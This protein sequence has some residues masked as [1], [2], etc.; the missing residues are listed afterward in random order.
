MHW[1]YTPYV[2]PLILAAVVSAPLTVY[3]WR[4]RAAPGAAPLALFMLA[5]AVWSLGTALELAG[6]DVATKVFWAEVQYLGVVTVPAAWLAFALQYTDTRDQ[7]GRSYLTRRNLALLAIEPLMTLLLVLTNDYHGLMWGPL[8]LQNEG[9][10]LV[11]DWHYGLWFW[12]NVAYS[13][14]LL[15][16]GLVRLVQVLW[17]SPGLYRGQI[18][19]LLLGVLVPWAAS[20]AY[21]TD[22]SPFPYLDLTPFAFTLTGLAVMWNLFRFG[23]LNLVPIARETVIEKMSEGVIV[24]DAQNRVVDI[25]PAACR[26]LNCTAAGT[27]GGAVGQVFAA[28]PD[29]ER[30]R[31]VPDAHEEI[32]VGEGEAQRYFDVRISPL[33]DWRGRLTGHLIVLRDITER[34][35]VEAALRES[36]ARYRALVE[37]IPPVVYMD[38]IDEV[39]S[40]LYISPQVETLLGYSPDEWRADPALWTKLLHPDDRERTLAENARTNATGEPFRAE[41]RLIARDGHVVWIRDEAVLLRDDAGQPRYRQGVMLDVTARKRAEEALAAER[42]LLRTLIDIVP[43]Y[44]YVKDT[45]SRFLAAN[46]AVARAMGAST[47]GSLGEKRL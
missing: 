5:V 8:A 17:R 4:R 25:N 46:V 42:S 36:E 16:V 39:S 2:A 13:Y 1:Q 10:F 47:P 34:K 31:N 3:A 28:W 12:F 38:A 30:Y 6:A 21:V 7:A 26:F 22:S 24:L 18:G 37:Q 35:R 14:V 41:Y 32:S 27:I 29:L 9:V 15:L 23:F 33:S 45:A 40:A 20:V 43:D 44:I 11:L 19:V